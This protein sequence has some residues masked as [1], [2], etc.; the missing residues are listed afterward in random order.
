M[1]P[2]LPLTTVTPVDQ[3]GKKVPGEAE[4]ELCCR[5]T[6]IKINSLTVES[7]DCGV[8]TIF[9]ANKPF[10]VDSEIQFY[11]AGALAL[12]A[13]KVPVQITYTAESYGPG[14]ELVIAT[15]NFNTA[16]GVL[17]YKAPANVA[18]GTLPGDHLYR[19]SMQLRMG[20]VGPQLSI[21]NGFISGIL[22]EA[23]N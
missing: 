23:Y 6:Y 7:E 14:P 22:V 18:A 16:A 20:A 19:I 4:M 8:D 13:L 3:E 5:P 10:K 1:S 17:V 9:P 12:M 11:G 2:I 21:A 15:V